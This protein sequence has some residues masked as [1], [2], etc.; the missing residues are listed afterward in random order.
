MS[1]NDMSL[2]FTVVA[3]ALQAEGGEVISIV[4]AAFAQPEQQLVLHL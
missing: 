2:R 1:R 4:A 3:A